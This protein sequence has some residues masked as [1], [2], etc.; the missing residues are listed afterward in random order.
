MTNNQTFNQ[1]QT[2]RG[3]S[4]SLKK[5]KSVE[6]RRDGTG[7]KGRDRADRS[8]LTI[9]FDVLSGKLASVRIDA[10]VNLVNLREILL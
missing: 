3:C 8:N 1:R 5:P 9:A 7:E 6:K 2:N 10:F 4:E